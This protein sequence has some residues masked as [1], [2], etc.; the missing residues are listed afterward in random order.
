L[1]IVAVVRRRRWVAIVVV[2]IMMIGNGPLNRLDH[3][4]M[5]SARRQHGRAGQKYRC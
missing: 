5:A 1:P 2:V 4:G 3:G